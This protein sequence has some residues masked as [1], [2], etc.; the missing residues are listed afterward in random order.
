MLKRLLRSRTAQ[1]AIGAVL[2]AYMELVRRTTRWEVRGRE[3]I[4]PIWA[5]RAGVIGCVWHARVLMTIAGWPRDVQ[6]ASILISRSPDG[7]FVAHAARRHG[8]G[9]VRGSAKNP[10]K[11]KQKG[12]VT[13]F[14]AMTDHVRG[15]GC[16]AMTPDGPRGPR[17]RVSPGVV[18]LARA[19][20]APMVA[21]A[22]S[23]SW[24]IVFG[25]WDRF[26]LPLPFGR[27][28]MVWKG[29]VAAP[30]G[31][32]PEAVEAAR[33]ELEALML[34]ASA[35]A[36]EAA[37]VAIIEPEPRTPPPVT[38][39]PTEPYPPPREADD[40]SAAASKISGDV[41]RAPRASGR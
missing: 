35:E 33:D 28:V 13:A 7:E 5:G 39:E 24:R 22:W 4:E 21:Y 10:K 40:P 11:S 29:P 30:I 15:G 34:A 3:V 2:A 17:M 19:T 1:G 36:D 9:V 31:D 20:G 27:G 37:G 16:M 12:G 18:R 25:S 14:R 32:D 26:I 8:I 41:S 6:P 23:T 38:P